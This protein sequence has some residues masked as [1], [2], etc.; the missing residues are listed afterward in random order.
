[1]C[2]LFAINIVQARTTGDAAGTIFY[3]LYNLENLSLPIRKELSLQ[4]EEHLIDSPLF[5]LCR[6]NEENIGSNVPLKRR[7]SLEEI[8]QRA[9]QERAKY[10]QQRGGYIDPLNP[11]EFTHEDTSILFNFINNALVGDMQL[12]NELPLKITNAEQCFKILSDGIILCKFFDKMIP[13][14]LDVRAINYKITTLPR[15]IIENWNLCVN[16]GKAVGCRLHDIDIRELSAG[17]SDALLRLTWQ[18]IR[19]G[20]E[21]RMRKHQS[22]IKKF[23]GADDDMENMIRLPAETLLCRWVNWVMQTS[24]HNRHVNSFESDFKDCE[25]LIVLLHSFAPT[26]VDKQQLLSEKDITKRAQKVVDLTAKMK[27]PGLVTVNGITQGILWQIFL[28]L[29][30]LFLASK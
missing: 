29:A 14:C 16:S 30:T 3:I 27:I 18:I 26:L 7:N 12:K 11:K 6:V 5:C 17:K 28:L 24:R 10:Q 20:L 1:M 15:D 4:F 23:V 9:A 25:V 22:L 13:G 21:N 8:R 2:R 19:V